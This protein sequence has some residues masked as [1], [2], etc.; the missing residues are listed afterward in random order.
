MI[1]ITE[2]PPTDDDANWI[3]VGLDQ[4][5]AVVAGTVTFHFG[6]EDAIDRARYL[7]THR[8]GVVDAYVSHV[9]HMVKGEF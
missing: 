6:R 7:I 2:I 8:P 9:T 5:A 1:T 4:R 3:V